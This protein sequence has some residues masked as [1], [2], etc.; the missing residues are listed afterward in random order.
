MRVKRGARA[1]EA[2]GRRSIERALQSGPP[3]DEYGE[4]R[5]TLRE[6]RAVAARLGHV[7]TNWKRRVYAP[8]TAATAYCKRCRKAAGV[9]LEHSSTAYGPATTDPCPDAG[10]EDPPENNRPRTN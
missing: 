8:N 6:G 10:C 5:R 2:E 3:R 9:N 4:L 1:V 7:L